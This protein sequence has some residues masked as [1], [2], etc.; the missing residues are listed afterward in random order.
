MGFKRLLPS[1]HSQYTTL[2][3]GPDG[4]QAS[5]THELLFEHLRLY[6]KPLGFE[7]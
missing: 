6:N 1:E 5:E 7:G 4:E 3:L 2:C